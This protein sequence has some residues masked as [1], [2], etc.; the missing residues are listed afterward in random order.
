MAVRHCN[1][2][3][4][5]YGQSGAVSSLYCNYCSSGRIGVTVNHCHGALR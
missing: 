2:K 3:R 4:M 1:R 5:S